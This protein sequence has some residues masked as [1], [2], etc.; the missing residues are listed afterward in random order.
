MINSNVVPSSSSTLPKAEKKEIVI[1]LIGK[2]KWR[3]P[4]TQSQGENT[5]KSSEETALDREAAEAVLK[6]DENN[7]DS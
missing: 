3:L 6:G 5:A 1:P 2:N 7:N 4:P